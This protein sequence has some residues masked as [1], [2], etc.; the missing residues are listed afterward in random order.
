MKYFV[1][2]YQDDHVKQISKEQAD[3]ILNAPREKYFMSMQSK[4]N[5]HLDLSERSCV[6][7]HCDSELD[8]YVV[9]E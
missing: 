3:D 4:V 8:L 1:H 9:D 7:I 5:Y 6:C 2:T